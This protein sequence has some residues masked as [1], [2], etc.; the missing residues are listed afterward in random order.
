MAESIAYAPVVLTSMDKICK[1]FGVGQP[2]VR[3]WAQAG[4][5]IAVVRDAQ[6]SPVRYWCEVMRLYAWVENCSRKS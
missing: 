5:P 6:G 1:H 4:A 2:K 3:E